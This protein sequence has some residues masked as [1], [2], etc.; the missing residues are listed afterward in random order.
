MRLLTL[1]A[2]VL[3]SLV[4]TSV[5]VTTLV[6]QSGNPAAPTFSKDVAPILYSKCVSCHRTGEIG[7]MS[8]ITYKDVRPW[9]ASIRDKVSNRIMPP[10]HADPKFGTFRNDRSLSTNEINTI[11]R[12]VDGG[13]REG[14]ASDLPAAP[15]FA[16]G[17]QIG[18][19]DAVFEMPTEFEIPARGT[20]D[21]QYFEVPTNFTEDRWLQA[22]EA[23]AGDRAHVHH[24]IV[25]VIEPAATRR[26]N[27]NVMNLKVIMPD[28][29]TPSAPFARAP[30]ELT[31]E[32]RAGAVR[33]TRFAGANMLVNWAVGEDAPVHPVGIAKRIPAG[34]TLLFQV[35]YTTNGTPGKDRSK[36]GMIFS[37]EPPKN[38]V[39]TGAIA[40]PAFA[41]PPGEANHLVEAEASFTS[42]VKIWTMHPHMHFRGKD[43]TYTATYPDGRSE[44]VLRVPKYDFNWQ[45]D[46]WLKEPL[47]L[48]K[49]STLRV[50]AHFDN[51]TANRAN[52]NPKE[53]VRWGDQTWE[54]MMIGFMTYTVEPS[55]SSTAAL[56]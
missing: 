9:A 16:D 8:L 21:Y 22:G 35:H 47:S 6:A 18:K 53:T 44:V 33:A 28:G 40:N 13:A 41:I 43:M 49:G 37:K 56:R 10:W 14:I 51:S 38:E 30:R 19:P 11:V 1:G 34:S 23:R 20:I 4:S 25:S 55:S 7:P 12:W 5:A 31:D 45:G 29:Q 46:Y 52:P 48:P 50:T 39:R 15:K 32:Q 26:P 42:D 2:L 3:T 17:W 27:A 24:I 54:E 36:I